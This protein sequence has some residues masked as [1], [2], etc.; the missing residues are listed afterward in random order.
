MFAQQ[1]NGLTML[2]AE[3]IPIAEPR[4]TVHVCIFHVFVD[5]RVF[6][7]ACACACISIR[8]LLRGC[9]RACGRVDT[10]SSWIERSLPGDTDPNCRPR[11]PRGPMQDAPCGYPTPHLPR[12]Q[13]SFL[14]CE[15][16][17]VLEMCDPQHGCSALMQQGVRFKR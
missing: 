6:I 4:T 14:P 15:V 3:C 16:L 13:C 5:V 9:I 1:R 8:D 12:R 17:G 11:Q 10:F 7:S 2:F